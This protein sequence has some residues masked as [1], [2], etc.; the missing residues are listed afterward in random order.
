MR[1]LYHFWLHPFSRKVRM[2]LVEKNVD[3]E[4]KIEKTKFGHKYYID[5]GP[6]KQKQQN[7]RN[8]IIINTIILFW[9]ISST[10][11]ILA[12]YIVILRYRN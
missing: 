2:A 10:L 5:Y 3:F 7:Y 1:T 11:T 9:R 6:I 12:N 8:W 4:L